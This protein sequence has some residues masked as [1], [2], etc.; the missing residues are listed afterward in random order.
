MLRSQLA[1]TRAQMSSNQKDAWHTWAVEN[2]ETA[3]SRGKFDRLTRG[4]FISRAML[5]PSAKMLVEGKR[6]LATMNQELAA[7]IES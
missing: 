5:L 4:E 1:A 7:I 3:M 2:I 6:M